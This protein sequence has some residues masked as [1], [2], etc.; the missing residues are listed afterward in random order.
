MIPS[1]RPTFSRPLIILLI[2]LVTGLLVFTFL[3]VA[4]A[5]PPATP[6][7]PRQRPESQAAP[8]TTTL[9][10]SN[11]HFLPLLVRAGFPPPLPPPVPM[12]ATP[13]VDF[14]AIQNLLEENDQALA[15]AK[16]GFHTGIDGNRT[17]LLEWMEALDAAGVPFFLKSADNAEPLFQAQTLM[18]QSGISHTLVYRK[19]GPGFDTPDYSRPPKEAAQIHWERHK[20]AF[21][22]ELDPALVWIETINEVDKGRAEWLGEF[23]VETARLALADGFR[24][25]AFGWATGEPEPEDWEL[26]PMRDFLRLAGQHPDRLAVAVHEYSLS[27]QNIADIYPWKLGRFQHLFQICDAYRIPRPTVLITEWG[28]QAD[29][30]PDVEQALADIHWAN[31][32][33]S[34][35]PQV[36][37]AAIWYLGTGYGGIAD[38]AQQLIEPVQEYNLSHYF[39]REQGQGGID[40]SLFLP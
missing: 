21:P 16:I 27:T 11:S 13:P 33:Y 7:A 3:D 26:A 17:G 30:V 15:F 5:T 22:P 20:S 19:S 36:K 40:A 9:P 28:W 1:M 25:A 23:A 6:P 10:M 14:A 8:L 29:A 12:T 34:A 31:W 32:L 4:A 38:Q 24:W 37:G 39:V 35:Y 18:Q 2:A